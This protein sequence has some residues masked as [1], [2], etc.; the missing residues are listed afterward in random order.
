MS[1]GT[2]PTEPPP[3]DPN[4][5]ETPAA[6]VEEPVA[7]PPPAPVA[8]VTPPAPSAALPG[9]TRRVTYDELSPEQV[10]NRAEQ[11]RIGGEQV[12][13]E[14]RRGAANVEMAQAE[15]DQ[16]EAEHEHQ[17]KRQQL[18][19]DA[20]NLGEQH[21]E[22]ARTSYQQAVAKRAGMKLSDLPLAPDILSMVG[23]ALGQL[24]AGARGHND[25]LDIL[26]GRLKRS[27]DV[28]RANI[29]AADDMV[30]MA[31]TGIRDAQEAK[32]ALIDDV[33]VNEA[34]SW[35]AIESQWRSELARRKVP[36]AQIDADAR[37]LAAQK[38][39]AEAEQKA[40]APTVRH[41]Q[42]TLTNMVRGK[43][44]VGGGG[45]NGEPSVKAQKDMAELSTKVDGIVQKVIQNTGYKE[46]AIQNRKYNEIAVTLAGAKDNAALAA[47]GA[48]S[49]VKM[50]QGGTG[51]ISDSDMNVFWGKI[52]GVPDR[53]DNYIETALSGKMGAAK[54]KIVAD[55][56]RTLAKSA[57]GELEKVGQQIQTRLDGEAADIPWVKS[58][59]PV[60]LDT[61]VPGLRGG[62]P[63]APAG[64]RM[65]LK[66]GETGVLSPDGTFTPDA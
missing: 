48:G 28:Q 31:K 29:A 5:L 47:A 1:I 15:Q 63:A 55:A 40:L 27:M 56:V 35:K 42:D 45:G 6:P 30:A 41:V 4:A 26:E 9:V 61:Y 13:V 19:T 49:W 12:K 37:V 22:E 58:R 2:V 50:A 39:A 64:K 36:A 59:I 38:N 65:R 33:N 18:I 62:K 23:L 60:Y 3:F 11:K 44:R 14:Q 17:G 25:A 34:A 32:K 53:V 52:G 43:H 54:Q 20:I 21:I 16:A 8:P 46:A 10:A 66:S 57:R 7:V 51:V 24:G